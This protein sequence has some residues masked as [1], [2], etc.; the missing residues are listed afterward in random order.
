MKLMRCGV[1]ATAF[2]VSAA[3]TG[4]AQQN[5]ALE[6]G[7]DAALFHYSYNV[8]TTAGDRSTSTNV[9]QFPVSAVRVAFPLNP[10]FSLEPSVNLQYSSVNGQNALTLTGDLGLLMDLTHDP[11]E[12][13]WYV[14]PAIGLQHFS[15]SAFSTTD[16]PT[17]SFGLGTRVPLTDRIAAR[18][19]ARYQWIGSTSTA[20]SQNG[21]GLLAGISVFTR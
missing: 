5:G 3:T 14:R 17:L 10:G 21:I 18:Y 11:K 15:S 4:A 6:F 9:F 20:G 1:L 13:R 19:E 7:M 2:A 16:R 12:W 8:K